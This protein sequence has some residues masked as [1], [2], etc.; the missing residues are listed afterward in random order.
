MRNVLDEAA[1]VSIT[2]SRRAFLARNCAKWSVEIYIHDFFFNVI[3]CLCCC[4]TCFS[5]YFL[6]FPCPPYGI[7]FHGVV[8][9]A[10]RHTTT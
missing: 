10:Q 4:L 5:L 2:A 1:G 6:S 3:V 8:V 9:C 7:V